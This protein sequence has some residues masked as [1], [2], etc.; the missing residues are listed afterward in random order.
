M[1]NICLV[2]DEQKVAA[3][4]SKGLE[5]QRYKIKIATS[6]AEAEILRQ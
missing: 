4:I 5:E 2:E 3:F 1:N 6:G